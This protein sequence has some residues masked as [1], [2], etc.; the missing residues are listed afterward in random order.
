MTGRPIQPEMVYFEER[1]MPMV[2]SG[3]HEWIGLIAEVGRA[4][5]N[6][7][8]VAHNNR[9]REYAYH[10]AYRLFKG[11]V[12]SG[13]QVCH[14]CDNGTCV[15]P[16]HLF[17][18]T[19]ADNMTDMMQKGRARR[20]TCHLGHSMDGEQIRPNGLIKRVCRTC[21]RARAATARLRRKEIV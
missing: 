2:W 8:P 4:K 11:P 3:C 6:F 7:R 5:G 17:L 18:G 20:L 1:S 14:T 10:M 19:Q 12:P 16:D 15:N 21:E 9:R 13:F